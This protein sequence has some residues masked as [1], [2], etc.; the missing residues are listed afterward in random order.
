MSKSPDI[1]EVACNAENRPITFTSED[2]ATIVECTYDS[3][4][5]RSTRK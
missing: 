2:G 3:M 5:R 1:R 4:G